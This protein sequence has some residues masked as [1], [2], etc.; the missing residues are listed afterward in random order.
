MRIYKRIPL[1]FF[2]IGTFVVFFAC[3]GSPSTRKADNPV[4]LT[5]SV[6]YTFL[7]PSCIATNIDEVQRIYGAYGEREFSFLM[8]TIADDN[9]ITLLVLNEMGSEVARI[10]FTDGVVVTSDLVRRLGFPAEYI[11]A[12]FQLAFY[13]LDCLVSA[14][15]SKGI[16]INED[17]SPRVRRFSEGNKEILRIDYYEKSLEFINSLRGYRYTIEWGATDE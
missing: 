12:D 14:L 1:C 9:G 3:T 16:S 7:D 4:F 10:T 8:Y 17:Y 5:N 15:S 13:R 2:S 11:V 6:M